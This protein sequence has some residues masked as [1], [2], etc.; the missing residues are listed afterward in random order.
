MA[1]PFRT[2]PPRPARICRY[3][4]PVELTLERSAFDP[5]PWHK[6]LDR[7]A[8]NTGF[9]RAVLDGH[10]DGEPVPVGAGAAWYA[11]HS[12]GM[13]LVW[14]DA[15]PDVFDELVALMATHRP[16]PGSEWL[17]ID[18]RWSGLPWRA[19]LEGAG[20]LTR[21]G[22]AEVRVNFAFD[23]AR[24]GTVRSAH[25]QLPDG[26]IIQPATPDD[27]GLG[28]AVVPA[29]FWRSAEQWMGHGGGWRVE[30]G[31]RL[32]ALAFVAFPAYGGVEIGIETAPEHRGQGLGAAVAVAIIDDVVGK[33]EVPLWA[34]RL[35]NGASYRLARRLGFAPTSMLPYFHLV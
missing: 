5:V 16:D 4:W 24:Y 19:A 29:L 23:P 2:Y 11:R 3:R 7:V 34:C 14:G 35:G 18:P 26:W 21:A 30:Q 28:G 32:G 8:I 13:S 31:G 6:A 12:C 17:Q 10:V 20:L 22:D 1:E 15:V 9:V 33:G 27:F 25:A